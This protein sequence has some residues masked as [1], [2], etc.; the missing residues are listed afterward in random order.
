MGSKGTYGLLF[1]T[2]EELNGTF[3]ESV[4]AC[5]RP[6]GTYG[7]LKATYVEPKDLCTSLMPNFSFLL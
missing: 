2:F 5:R 3:R 7:G 6:K 4:R 1:G